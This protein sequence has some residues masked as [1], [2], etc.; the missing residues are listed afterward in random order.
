LIFAKRTNRMLAG[1]LAGALALSVTPLI[2]LAGTASAADPLP[3]LADPIGAGNFCENAPTTEP[4]TDVQPSDN[5]YDEIICLVATGLTTGVT[6]TS[7][8]PAASIT[9]RQMA[10]FIK[11]TADLADELEITALTALPAY[12]GVPDFADIA[13]ESAAIKEAIGQLNQAAIVQGTTAATYSPAQTVSRRQ[14]AAFINRLQDFLTGDPFTTTGDFFDDDEGDTG[15]ANLNAVASVGIFQGDGAGNVDPGGNLSRRQMAS[16][17]LRYAQVLFDAGDIDGA[18]EPA[19]NMDFGVVGG[20]VVRQLAGT[21]GTGTLGEVPYTFTGLDPARDYDAALL[22]C[23]D[24]DEGPDVLNNAGFVDLADQNLNDQADNLGNTQEGNAEIATVGFVAIN[25]PYAD[26]VSPD[27]DGTLLVRIDSQDVDCAFLT[28]FDDNADDDVLNLNAATTDSY[29]DPTDDFAVAGPVAYH[30][31]EAATGTDPSGDVVYIDKDGNF[32]ILD[33]GFRYNYDAAD[34]GH[35]CGAE[36]DYALTFAQ[37]EAT[38][39]IGD[40]LDSGCDIA[41]GNYSRT[42]PNTFQ[43]DDDTVNRPTAATLTAVDAPVPDVDLDVDDV[44]VSWTAPSPMNGDVDQYCVDILNATTLAFQASGCT[45]EVNTAGTG[46]AP[47]TLTLIDVPAGPHVARVYSGS[48][49]DDGSYY[50]DLS[51]AATT[52]PPVDETRPF[53][54]DAKVTTDAGLQDRFDTGDVITLTFNEDMADDIGS[55]GVFVVT[56]ADGDTFNFSC[57]AVATVT[58]VLSDDPIV[59]LNVDRVLTMTVTAAIADTN[60]PG[61][62]L[63]EMPATITTTNASVRDQ[64]GNIVNLATSTDVIVDKEP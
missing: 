55:T 44:T 57:A 35:Y 63:L 51:N 52:G 25:S 30:F 13:G 59:P 47:T 56:D 58:C 36:V 60:G 61:D 31:G 48:E 22:Q 45:T 46:D 21:P 3:A 32:F 38:L 49:T 43:I 42:N 28:V 53:I 16:V 37:L 11:R 9:R 5:A 20:P 29:N 19:T 33:D 62:G 64:A 7:Y 27:A 14:M 54:T 1:T 23:G 18:F 2:G 26:D 39:S 24:D 34:A 10:L 12:D 50:S 8:Q 15:E 41:T 6:S 17:L 4:F 40:L